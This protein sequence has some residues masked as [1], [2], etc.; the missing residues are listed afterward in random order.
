MRIV[1][2]KLSSPSNDDRR[3][4]SLHSPRSSNA[5]TPWSSPPRPRS[6]GSVRAL[7]AQLG[8]ILPVAAI[9]LCLNEGQP[10]SLV[11]QSMIW[12]HPDR[13]SK[14][15]E[16][17]ATTE[18]IAIGVTSIGELTAWTFAEHDFTADQARYFSLTA[19]HLAGLIHRLQLV[20]LVA[21]TAIEAERKRIAMDLHD[22]VTQRMYSVSFLADATAHQA[23]LDPTD[24]AQPVD[25]IRELVLLSLADLRALLL[26]LSP[27]PFE[28]NPLPALLVQLVDSLAATSEADIVID[29]EPV[30]SM[31]STVKTALY[32][33][34]QEALSNAC[35]HSGASEIIVSLT[36][37][38]DTAVLVID[39]N[40]TGF[41]LDATPTGSGI[42]NI[43]TRSQHIDA[44]L[45]ITS[46]PTTGTTVTVYRSASEPGI[47]HHEE[48]HT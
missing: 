8:A 43:R 19:E 26:E 45:H 33:I 3:E 16:C 42:R 12:E 4:A 39:D 25:R 22:S 41:D 28:D 6:N 15:S 14:N 38:D 36:T 46:S 40:G 5:P 21:D 13:S 7:L 32:R 29:C 37:H 9:E 48:A 10:E 23:R 1:A 35:R 2:S 44:D 24:L 20:A 27:Q 18:S 17:S 30:P 31:T 11:T 34:T 47:R